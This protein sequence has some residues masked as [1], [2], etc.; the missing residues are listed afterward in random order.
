MFWLRHGKLISNTFHVT[1][2][3]SR[4][5]RFSLSSPSRCE[6]CWWEWAEGDCLTSRGNSRLQRGRLQ[7]DERHRGRSH[8]DRLR[9]RGAARQEDQRSEEQQES[10]ESEMI[11]RRCC[12]LHRCC[13]VDAVGYKNNKTTSPPNILQPCYLC[14]EM[15]TTLCRINTD[16]ASD[17]SRDVAVYYFQS[18]F[19]HTTGSFQLSQAGLTGVSHVIEEK[20]LLSLLSA[21]GAEPAPPPAVVAA[22]RDL[23]T[24]EITARSFRVTWTHA[25]GQVEKYRV[26]YY[27][28]S[29]GQPEEKVFYLFYC[30]SI[31]ILIIFI[32]FW[33]FS[34]LKETHFFL[35]IN[36]NHAIFKKLQIVLFIFHF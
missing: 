27:P 17:S 36:A 3:D 22:P 21:G 7:R 23:V 34:C 25:S 28:A 15:P 10:A 9:P 13:F 8:Q 24:S 30:W 19:A 11:R 18:H 16:V 14:N 20:S 1:V 26:V 32:Y 33:S 6:K 12:C 31:I 4:I 2:A 35:A 5:T 29:G